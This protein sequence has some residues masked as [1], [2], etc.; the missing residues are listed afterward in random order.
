MPIG[1]EDIAEY[2]RLGELPPDPVATMA[3]LEDLL[4][5]LLA[6]NPESGI[7]M[8]PPLS[9]LKELDWVSRSRSKRSRSSATALAADMAEGGA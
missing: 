2:R 3:G 8:N 6:P 4:S 7:G 9:L 1:L 5:R